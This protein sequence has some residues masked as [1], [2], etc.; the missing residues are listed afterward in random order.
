MEAT[1]EKP[2]YAKQAVPDTTN[3]F[4]VKCDEGWRSSIVCMG[5][6]EWAADWL[7]ETLQ[8]RPYAPGTR[9]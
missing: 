4:M 7:V 3:L 9:P 1:P 5:M 8:G 6:Y 2:I